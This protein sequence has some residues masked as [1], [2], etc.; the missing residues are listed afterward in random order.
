MSNFQMAY[1][2]SDK[3]VIGVSAA[4]PLPV[5]AAAAAPLNTVEVPASTGATTSVASSATVVT[6]KALNANRKKISIANDSTAILY[7]LL[8][9]GT[10]STTVYSFAL[11]AKSGVAF[12]RTIE[13]Y[14]GVITGIWASANGFATITEFT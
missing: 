2:G 5:S 13:G 14:T 9:A 12:D 4:N 6:L 7:V 3:T 10:V 8:G 1:V 11:A